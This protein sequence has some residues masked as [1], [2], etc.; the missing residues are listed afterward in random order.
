MRA[1]WPHLLPFQPLRVPG[2]HKTSSCIRHLKPRQPFYK[3]ASGRPR[4]QTSEAVSFTSHKFYLLHV[5][6]LAACSLD[7]NAQCL[8]DVSL[9]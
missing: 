7:V 2:R 6:W 1:C 3:L 5:A 4:S 9:R 8:T